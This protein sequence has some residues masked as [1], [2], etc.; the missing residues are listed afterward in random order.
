M[1]VTVVI[2]TKKSYDLEVKNFK[3]ALSLADYFESVNRTP[4]RTQNYTQVLSKREK[5]N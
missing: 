3:E 1:K 5:V 2:T 4:D